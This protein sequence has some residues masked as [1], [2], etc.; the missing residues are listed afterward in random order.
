VGGDFIGEGRND[1][2]LERE[3]IDELI[4]KRNELAGDVAGDV[5]GFGGRGIDLFL[6]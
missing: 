5:A 3:V 6:W 4:A 1:G 2:G